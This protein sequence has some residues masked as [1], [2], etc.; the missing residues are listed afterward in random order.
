V[1]CIR[2]QDNTVSRVCL[3]L[4]CM[5]SLC[6]LSDSY[7]A[8]QLVAM[9]ASAFVLGHMCASCG[10]DSRQTDGRGFRG[11]SCS[12]ASSQEHS[13]GR[14]SQALWLVS[15]ACI[16]APCT[17]VGAALVRCGVSCVRRPLGMHPCM[18][19]A[20]VLA[21]GCMCA[22]ERITGAVSRPNPAL[23]ALCRV[24]TPAL[25]T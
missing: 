5:L 24:C 6:R 11:V 20:D 3:V 16:A 25:C 19:L 10:T 9:H 1:W 4:L 2:W 12:G 8:H 15:P 23:T 13:P 18:R 7:S 17:N 22:G 14:A 21:T